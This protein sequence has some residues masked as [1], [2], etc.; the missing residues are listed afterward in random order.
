MLESYISIEYMPS[1]TEGVLKRE[2]GG[3]TDAI[4]KEIILIARVV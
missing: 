3:I 1:V 2:F 4:T